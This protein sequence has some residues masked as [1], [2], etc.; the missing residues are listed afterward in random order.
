LIE[1][2]TDSSITLNVIN[3]YQGAKHDTF[4]YFLSHKKI[5]SQTIQIPIKKVAL[6]STTYIGFIDAL[7]ELNSITAISGTNLLITPKSLKELNKMYL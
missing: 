6:F 5:N 2:H 3:P 4:S 7:N 1:K